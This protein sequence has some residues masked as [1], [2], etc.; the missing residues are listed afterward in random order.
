V[1]D[2]WNRR[3]QKFSPGTYEPL[4]EW[5]VEGW[6]TESVVNKPY[7]RVDGR[8]RVYVGDP[9]GYRVLV[10]DDQGQFL[11]SFGQ[12]GFD[13]ASFT[14]PLGMAFDATGNLYVVDSDNSRVLKF[15]AASLQAELP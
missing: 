2:T 14:L 8:G 1:A 11:M 13:M 3:V 10:F 9:E 7:L 15:E 4:A 12:Y 6:E 5:P